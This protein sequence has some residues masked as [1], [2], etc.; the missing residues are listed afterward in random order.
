MSL[1][2]F[3]VEKGFSIEGVV[4]FITGTGAPS[5][6]GGT[7]TALVGIGSQYLDSSQGYLYI[8]R[9][10]G[11]G[12][13][14]WVRQATATE[15]AM[16]SWREPALCADVVSTSLPT[17]GDLETA[18]GISI[19]VGSRVLFSAISGGDGAN[20]YI[21]NGTSFVEDENT[22][23]AGDMVYIAAGTQA[24]KTYGYTVGGTWVVIGQ[25]SS[26][27]IGYIRAYIGKAAGNVLPDYSSIYYIAD[28]DTLVTAIGKLDTALNTVAGNLSNEITA[29][30]NAD[31]LLQSEL[32]D[33]QA[34]AGLNANGTYS[35]SGTA[36]YISTA[37]SLK[38]AD[39][40]LDAQLKSV[41][42]DVA[43]LETAS[44]TQAALLASARTETSQTNV[45]SAVT[46][47]EVLVDNVAVA[48]WIVFAKGTAS[49]DSANRRVLEVL[50][51]HDGTELADAT[52]ADSTKYAVLKLGSIT[53]LT[54]TVD[55]AGSAGA[56]T[57]RLRVSST[58]AADVKAIREII[59]L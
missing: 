31:S 12:A 49:G 57:M 44:S 38:S 10:A 5:G 22:E 59:A 2:F 58:M 34:G 11:A 41:S 6:T 56:Q 45:T 55:L 37:T 40:M 32:N 47:D 28:G 14:N 23:T 25:A 43:A 42:D 48:K 33:T 17:H 1:K 15:V 20:V 18:Q 53:G 39:N 21:W 7:D 13:A 52:N 27:E 51:M 9:V 16:L 29:R 46:L 4:A 24:G 54:V 36:N 3:D 30:G 8:K 50:A 26:D 35:P 19:P